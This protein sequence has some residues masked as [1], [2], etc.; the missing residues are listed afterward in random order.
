MILLIEDDPTD[1][2]F[3]RRAFKTLEVNRP[4]H[5]VD[6]GRA[7]IDYLQGGGPRP[8]HVLLDLKLP[9]KSGF[10]VLEWI[11]ERPELRDLPVA[12]LTSS[13]EGSDIRRAKDLKADGYF[14]KPMSFA[15]LLEVAKTIEHWLRTGQAP[16]I[17]APT[18]R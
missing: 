1:V 4:M 15:S 13:S 18:R 6:N 5:V 11:R 17:S 10:E 16:A 14:V 9:E 3:L 7:A 2:L 12:I 8:T